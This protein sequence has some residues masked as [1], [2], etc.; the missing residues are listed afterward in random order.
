MRR[1][2][3]A[4]AAEEKPGPLLEGLIK[5][6][7]GWLRSGRVRVFAR[8]M[9]VGCRSGGGASVWSGIDWSLR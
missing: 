6:T 3:F 7:W 9:R 8:A 5:G 2:S 1:C 4:F